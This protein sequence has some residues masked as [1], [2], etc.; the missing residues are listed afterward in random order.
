MGVGIG[1]IPGADQ[2]IVPVD[3]YVVFVAEHWDH[4]IDRLKRLRI[5]TLPS[6]RLGVLNC[7]ARIGG[8]RIN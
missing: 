1:G 2:P 8:G 4:E 3:A 5:S 6:F 7:P